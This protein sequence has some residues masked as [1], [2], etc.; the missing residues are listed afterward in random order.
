MGMY[1]AIF[2]DELINP[3]GIYKERLSQSALVAEMSKVSD[4]EAL[5]VRTWLDDAGMTFDTGTDEASELT[6][7]PAAQPD[8]DVRRRPSYRR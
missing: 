6:G 1:N 8:E 2:D 4:E 5:A 7:L 3:M